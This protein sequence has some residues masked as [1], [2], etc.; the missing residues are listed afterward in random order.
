MLEAG[1][2]DCPGVPL[3]YMARYSWLLLKLIGWDKLQITVVDSTLM[4]MRIQDVEG[5]GRLFSSLLLL[6]SVG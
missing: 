3:A 4:Q 5:E 2:G 1:V 6:Q